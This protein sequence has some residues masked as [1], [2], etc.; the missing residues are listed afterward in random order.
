MGAGGV[1]ST[2]G[3][4]SKKP[5]AQMMTS[6][7]MAA[8]GTGHQTRISFDLELSML[9]GLFVFNRNQK[10]LRASSAGPQHGL[11]HDALRRIVIG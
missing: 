4:V 11:H 9:W 1:I 6:Q 5:N 10:V 2:F 3:D 7:I 8:S